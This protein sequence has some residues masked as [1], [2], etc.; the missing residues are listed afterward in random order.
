MEAKEIGSE[1]IRLFI[2]SLISN[3]VP[4]EDKN[5]LARIQDK[6]I[7]LNRGKGLDNESLMQN[8]QQVHEIS[9]P[10]ENLLQKTIMEKETNI[11]IELSY[12]FL[13]PSRP[14]ISLPSRNRQFPIPLQKKPIA[15]LGKKLPE[16]SAPIQSVPKP[17][18][19]RPSNIQKIDINSLVKIEFLLN[20]SA[21]QTIECP[22]PGKQIL[23]YK[24]GVIQTTNLSLTSEEI[25]N[26]MKE[27]S[28]KTRIPIVSGIFK[29]AFSDFITTAV[30]SEFVGT[31]FIIQKKSFVQQP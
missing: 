22:G 14:K 26:I 5:R 23:V 17:S 20:D 16:T 31:R 25:T 21:V 13:P 12:P 29:A 8:V 27:I 2:K 11:P 30:I 18:L 10:E 15:A 28:E 6:I 24:S 7:S 19:S 4:L 9:K 1:F 3:S